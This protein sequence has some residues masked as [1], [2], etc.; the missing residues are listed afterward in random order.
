MVCKDIGNLGWKSSRSSGYRFEP[1]L[2]DQL[3]DP[4][5]AG[6]VEVAVLLE[7]VAALVRCA[8]DMV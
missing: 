4:G 3:G 8:G 7:V 2:V 5:I 6:G 1:V